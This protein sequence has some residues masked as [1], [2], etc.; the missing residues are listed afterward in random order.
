MKTSENERL[1][2][3]GY[4]SNLRSAIK[5]LRAATSKEEATTLFRKV[6]AL[7]DKSASYGLIH[8]K[9]ASRNKSRLA[10]FVQKLG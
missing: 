8:K 4:R 5:E 9:N 1:R 10:S 3:R 2:N 7:L 6:T